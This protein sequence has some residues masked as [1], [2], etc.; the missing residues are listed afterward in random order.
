MFKFNQLLDF[1]QCSI[2]TTNVSTW[3]VLC[4]LNVKSCQ[5]MFVLFHKH[6]QEKTLKP[7]Y[8]THILGFCFLFENIYMCN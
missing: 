1:E 6:T 5:F 7:L 2:V 8:K 3:Q 4:L